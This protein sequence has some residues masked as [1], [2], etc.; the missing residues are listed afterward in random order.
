MPLV[1]PGITANNMGD[2]KT[3]EWMS[4][5]AGKTL[6][7]GPSSETA[8][9]K[10]DLPEETRVIEPGSMVTKDFKPERL[11]VHVKEDGTVSHVTHG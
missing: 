1:V 10:T 5:L 11:N 8:F 4:K 6:C 3:Q 9:C 7:E 2:D